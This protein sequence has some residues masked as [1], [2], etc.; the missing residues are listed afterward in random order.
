MENLVC[1]IL[2][3]IAFR[4]LF[5]MLEI[6]RT[7]QKM[8]E[9]QNMAMLVVGITG[10]PLLISMT[11]YM[12]LLLWA[13]EEA[14]IETSAI[15]QGKKLSVIKGSGGMLS[16][17][18]IFSFH[19]ELVTQKVKQIPTTEKGAGYQEYIM[20]FSFTRSIKSKLYYAM[21]LIQETI[22]YQYRDSFRMRN[23][24]I[25]VDFSTMAKLKKKYNTNVF[26]EQAYELKWRQCYFY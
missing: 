13:V 26:S 12:L 1:M 7:P 25:Q 9:L 23:V 14:I 11:K 10:I 5:T 19:P 18:E 20:L 3:L 24:L 22:R 8:V 16:Y 15:L 6:I 2:Y 4:T 21:D 17:Q